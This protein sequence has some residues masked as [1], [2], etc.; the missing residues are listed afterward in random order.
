MVL[1]MYNVIS[2]ML[3]TIAMYEKISFHYVRHPMSLYMLFVFQ[4]SIFTYHVLLGL[5]PVWKRYTRSSIRDKIAV[6]DMNGETLRMYMRFFF[7]KSN[8][9]LKCHYEYYSCNSFF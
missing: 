3:N 9:R 5:S 1:S 6:I 2:S 7:F 8:K 4:T